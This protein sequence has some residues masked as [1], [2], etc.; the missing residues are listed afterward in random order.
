MKKIS[1]MDSGGRP[2]AGRLRLSSRFSISS[3]RFFTTAPAEFSKTMQSGATGQRHRRSAAAGDGRARPRDR[4]AHRLYRLSRVNGPNGP[5][6]TKYLGG[7]GSESMQH[8]H[9]RE[10]QP[11]VRSGNGASP[12]IERSE[13]RA[14]SGVFADGHVVPSSAMPF[15]NF[16]NWTEEDRHA[17]L[18][19]CDT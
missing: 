7:G 8:R 6:Y 4:R 18:V 11:D 15:A 16:S 12:T 3:R 9:V 19:Y 10:P 1:Q 14:R 2:A 17:V 13:T 5:D